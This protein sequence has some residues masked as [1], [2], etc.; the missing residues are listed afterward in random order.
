MDHHVTK[1]SNIALQ[2]HTFY[3]I[4]ITIEQ[5]IYFFERTIIMSFIFVIY[6]TIAFDFGFFLL[7]NVVL[8]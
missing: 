1:L 8:N 5:Q 4:D 6:Y 7:Q 3:S 2:N